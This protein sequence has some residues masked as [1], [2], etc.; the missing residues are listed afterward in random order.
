[1]VYYEVSVLITILV[2]SLIAFYLLYKANELNLGILISISI[3]S[4]ILGFTFG[5]AFNYMLVLFSKS[6]SLNK[7]IILILSVL[8]VLVIFLFFILIISI[9]ISLCIPKKV[10]SIDCGLLIG[11]LMAKLKS[12]DNS[13]KDEF[14]RHMQD[15]VNYVHN[16]RNNLKKPVDTI[17]IIDTMGIEKNDN[18]VID[19]FELHN[20]ETSYSD[21][22]EIEI[23]EFNTISELPD[24]NLTIDTEYN[25]LSKYDDLVKEEVVA[26]NE[27]YKLYKP[28]EIT[29]EAEEIDKKVSDLLNAEGTEDY[30]VV[31]DNLEVT[32]EVSDNN[33]VDETQNEQIIEVTENELINEDAQNK[34]FID[35]ELYDIFEDGEQDYT[36]ENSL[37]DANS[38]VV[39]AFNFK[40][41]GRKEEAIRHYFKALDY[42]PDNEMIF[43]IVLDICTLYKQLGLSDLAS[44]IL[45]GLVNDYGSVIQP[46]IKDEILNN[47]K[48]I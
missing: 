7:T 28:F 22:S 16:L 4:I 25:E 27:D 12:K 20:A 42:N 32:E 19:R 39:K 45:E 41:E 5:P 29:G 11:K 15:L 26:T 10:A 3:G 23:N 35:D 40:D 36:T 31:E 1:M 2:T 13:F 44:S 8:A 37:L 21:V 30:E 34:L 6:L 46:E 47:L 17:Q 9:I 33:L 18:F 24:T 48:Q 14:I 43:W 38:L